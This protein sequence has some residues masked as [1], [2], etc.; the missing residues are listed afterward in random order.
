M[1]AAFKRVTG[2]E[3]ILFS[4]AEAALAAPDEPVRQ[5]VFP[6]V[7]GVRQRCGTWCRSTRAA[8]RCTGE[9]CRPR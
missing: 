4:I 8:V 7:T 6:A 5:V 3:N 2:K 1:V 9:R